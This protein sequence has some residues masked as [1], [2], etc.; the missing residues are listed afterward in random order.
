MGIDEEKLDNPQDAPEEGQ[1]TE[2]TEQ[3][4][5]DN[6]QPEEGQEQE[7]EEEEVFDEAK[8][9]EDT[10]FKSLDALK[11]S[12]KELLSYKTKLEQERSA[13]RAQIESL[14]R[15]LMELKQQIEAE[16][17]QKELG[18]DDEKFIE[19]F[20]QKPYETVRTIADRIADIK[21][22]KIKEE[23]KAQQ[24]ISKAKEKVAKWVASHKDVTDEDLALMYNII[25]KDPHLAKSPNALDYAYDI[26]KARYKSDKERSRI[27]KKIRSQI[28]QEKKGFVEGD[29]KSGGGKKLSREEEY[30]QGI[31]SVKDK[32]RLAE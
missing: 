17:V 1:A 7:K 3:E 13:S 12:Y 23:L 27:E 16:K 18:L 4:D 8:F 11:K 10:P 22:K 31:L 5:L 25:A 15:S 2:G 19:L 14:Q 21:L 20:R 24:S 30:L 26:V 29:S 28:E 32:V 9:L 6:A